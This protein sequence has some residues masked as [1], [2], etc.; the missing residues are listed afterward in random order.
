M[1]NIA[2]IYFNQPGQWELTV[3]QGTDD[4]GNIL[5]TNADGS[6]F[7]LTSYVKWALVIA[8]GAGPFLTIVPTFI[9]SPTLGVLNVAFTRAQLAAASNYNCELWSKDTSGAY[10]RWAVGP[11]IIKPT[12]APTIT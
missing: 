9:G 4:S 8:S 5:F 12:L 10:R 6:A 11:F 1:A 2:N 3:D 7:D